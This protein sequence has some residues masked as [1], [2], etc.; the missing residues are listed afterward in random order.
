MGGLVAR[1]MMQKI[2]LLPDDPDPGKH[3]DRRPA[4]DLISKF[5][6][7]GTPHGGISFDI[8]ALNWAEKAFGP[9][10]SRHL[11]AGEDVRLPHA[12]RALR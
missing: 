6:T 5:F 7:Y 11:R 10:G 3:H 9:A 12:R 4:K 1:C 2:C 8:G